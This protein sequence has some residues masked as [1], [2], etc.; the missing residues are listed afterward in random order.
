MM[1][2]HQRRISNSFKD[3]PILK[4]IRKLLQSASVYLFIASAYLAIAANQ[5]MAQSSV[6]A[7]GYN[8]SN[9]NHLIKYPTVI[10]ISL[11]I[12]VIGGILYLAISRSSKDK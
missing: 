10:F 2:N 4:S 3:L 6:L 12:L 1:D 9:H 11:A 7:G 5:V 8:G